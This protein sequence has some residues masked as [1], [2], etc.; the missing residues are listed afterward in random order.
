M[1]GGPSEGHHQNHGRRQNQNH[2]GYQDNHAIIYR[3][4]TS[5]ADAIY[6]ETYLL[7]AGIY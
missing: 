7:A 2:H 5:S 4:A 6:G 3:F 1:S